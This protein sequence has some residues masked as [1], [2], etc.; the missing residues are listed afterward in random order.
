M[1]YLKIFAIYIF[2][3]FLAFTHVQEAKAVNLGPL[4]V[5]IGFCQQIE[6]IGAIVNSFTVVQWPVGGFPGIT[7]GM[8]SNTSVVMDFCAYI[9]QME[10][11]DTASATFFTANYLNTLT[12]KKWD[13]HLQQADRTFNLANSIYDFENGSTRQGAFESAGTYRQINDYV[14]DSY[15]WSNKT[16]NGRD[17]ELQTRGQR[18]ADMQRLAGAAYQRAILKEMMNCPEPQDKDYGKIYQQLIAPQE[19]KKAEAEEDY[20]YYKEKLLSM[21]PRFLD[22]VDEMTKFIEEVEKLENNGIGYDIKKATVKVQTKKADPKKKDAEGKPVQNTVT[23]SRD[24]QDFSV[25]IVDGAWKNFD[26]K[27]N[28]RW[29]NYVT[30]SIMAAGSFGLLDNPT[31]RA[32]AEFRDLGFECGERKLMRGYDRN[33]GD[34][35]YTL[36]KAQKECRANT[37]MNEKKA[38]NLFSEF[39]KEMQNALY[40]YKGANAIIWTIESREMGRTR[41]VTPGAT[42]S[43]GFQQEQVKCSETLTPAEMDKLGLKQQAV[44]NELN[45]MLYQETMKQT[46]MKENQMKA[47]SEFMKENNIRQ[48][49]IEKKKKEQELQRSVGPSIQPKRG[50]INTGGN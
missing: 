28:E 13:D 45:E 10:Q 11:L 16:F 29:K 46:I 25:K 19:V 15:K 50:G 17:A 40:R 47:Q 20:S 4:S 5:T 31:A 36:E 44:A 1:K 48:D 12:G 24:Y 14:K 8:L 26:Q 30:M 6:K 27:Y 18:E 22:N 41:V 35:D 37:Q 49:Q 43:A 3:F 38:S 21:G 7:I 39:T 34:Y 32:E 9:T 23:L 2:A 42:S 33:K